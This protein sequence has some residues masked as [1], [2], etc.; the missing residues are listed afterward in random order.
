M[1]VRD[2]AKRKDLPPYHAMPSTW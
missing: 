1:G 2:K